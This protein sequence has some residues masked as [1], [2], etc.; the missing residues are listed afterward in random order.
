MTWTVFGAA[1]ASACLHATWNMLAKTAAAPRSLLV[2]IVQATATI[3]AAGALVIGLP[4]PA[5]WPWLLAGALC[6][7]IYVHLAVHAYATSSFGVAYAV[8]RAVI[9]PMMF[10]AGA[11]WLSESSRGHA[12][13]GF[14]LVVAGLAVLCLRTLS[15]ER[16]RQTGFALSAVAGLVLA[17]AL[18]LDIA[19][20]RAGG[21]G[22]LELARYA[23]A[24]SLATAGVLT[25]TSLVARTAPFAALLA[26]PRLC[27]TGAVL[28]LASYGFGMWAYTQGPVG[29]VAP[30][31]EGGILFA[32]VLAVLVLRERI[33]PLQWLAIGLATAGVVLIQIA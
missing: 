2:G 10:L 12:L 18:L 14:L 30:L 11:L 29:L 16:T 9:P 5:T 1:L 17:V 13:L 15:D 31:R 21:A 7:V 32:G 20:L 26:R 19:G 27:Y 8:V 3:C 24:S 4:Q 25:L 22:V 28:L 23:A 33:S 6:N